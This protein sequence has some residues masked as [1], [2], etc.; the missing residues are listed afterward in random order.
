[1]TICS[2]ERRPP[3]NQEPTF[4]KEPRSLPLAA[5]ISDPHLL[6]MLECI[7]RNCSSAIVVWAQTYWQG[8][9]RDSQNPR[10]SEKFNDRGWV[11]RSVS[12]YSSSVDY[13]LGIQIQ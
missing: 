4:P 11:G 13:Q 5:T 12:S 8:H 7:G 3:L 2:N 6:E 1:V 10:Y 9:F